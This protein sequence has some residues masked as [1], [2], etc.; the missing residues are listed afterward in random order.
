MTVVHDKDLPEG[1]KERQRIAHEIARQSC[2][3]VWDIAI[4]AHQKTGLQITGNEA[5]SYFG[6]IIQDFVALWIVG[7]DRIRLEDDAGV[8]REDLIKELMNGILS[9]IGC[10]ASYEEEAPLPEG[11]KKLKK[12]SDNARPE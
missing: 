7:M 10:S 2:E 1:M 8:L 4:E 6:T 3:Q 11:I 12:E 5:L 9:S